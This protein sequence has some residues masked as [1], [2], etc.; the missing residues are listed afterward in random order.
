M[1]SVVVS[2][3]TTD[4]QLRALLWYFRQHIRAGDFRSV[5]ILKPTSKHWGKP[6]YLDGMILIYRGEKCANESYLDSVG[7]CGYGEHDDA[8]Y[9]W[10]IDGEPAKDSA[11]LRLRNGDEVTVFD[12]KDGWQPKK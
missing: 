3:S 8:V 6:D 1:I 4:Q 2:P 12:Y 5:G 10:G 9:Q 11:G 7:P